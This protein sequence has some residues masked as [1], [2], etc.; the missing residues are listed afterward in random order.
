MVTSIGITTD[1]TGQTLI[2]L[3]SCGTAITATISNAPAVITLPK[4]GF[5]ASITDAA[6]PAPLSLS[7][8]SRC[9]CFNLEQEGRG[10]GK[11]DGA[12]WVAVRSDRDTWP[13]CGLLI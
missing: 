12:E 8:C 5:E 6:L 10:D 7:E 2:T 3:S 1:A 4:T 11:D 13:W 9:C